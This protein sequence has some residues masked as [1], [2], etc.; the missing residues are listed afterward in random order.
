MEKETV[1]KRTYVVKKRLHSITPLDYTLEIEQLIYKYIIPELSKHTP[2]LIQGRT[3]NE[4]LVLERLED[5]T[6]YDFLLD[7]TEEELNDV[8]FQLVFTLICFKRFNLKHN[9]LHLGN[10]LIVKHEP[11]IYT[12][13]ISHTVYKIKTCFTPKII[14]FDRAEVIH[15]NV[16]SNLFLFLTSASFEFAN[17]LYSI[18][19]WIHKHSL[20]HEK[21][22]KLRELILQEI[23][24]LKYSNNF[25][26]ECN[27]K[28][29]SYKHFIKRMNI[30][31]TEEKYLYKLPSQKIIPNFENKISFNRNIYVRKNKYLINII[32]NY[33]ENNYNKHK[34][35]L[36]IENFETYDLAKTIGLTPDLIAKI[37][38]TEV[39][40]R[41]LNIQK[42]YLLMCLIK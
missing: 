9:D 25:I 19:F 18:C 21:F 20:E 38:S 16:P 4:E 33:I 3:V 37:L 13:K 30:P 6:F 15:E 17:D 32:N 22:F 36:E 7:C 8:F 40:S 14:D 29:P 26:P 28:V 39:L 41:V 23:P 34:Y 2:C 24:A 31:V 27:V 12:F 11:V 42:N 1:I 35:K 5:Y 10:I